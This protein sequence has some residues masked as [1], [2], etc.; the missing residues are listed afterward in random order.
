MLLLKK[1][2]GTNRELLSEFTGALVDR[3][4]SVPDKKVD[5]IVFKSR[6]SPAGIAVEVRLP[7]REL[8]QELEDRL[9]RVQLYKDRPRQGSDAGGG[10]RS[11]PV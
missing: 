6:P 2:L 3:L 10:K 5:V 4:G 9:E 8:A 1:V 11:C 7:F